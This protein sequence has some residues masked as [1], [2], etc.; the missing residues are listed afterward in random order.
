M[1]KLLTSMLLAV[2]LGA[3][4]L[5]ADIYT[6]LH[7][8]YNP[9]G[10]KTALDEIRD[11]STTPI[12]GF[13][14]SWMASEIAPV[15]PT[16][17][18]REWAKTKVKTDLNLFKSWGMKLSVG[19]TADPWGQWVMQEVIK[20]F[21]PESASFHQDNEPSPFSQRQYDLTWAN[22]F[23]GTEAYWRNSGI[24]ERG[25]KLY[26]PV[27]HG[28]MEWPYDWVRGPA[29]STSYECSEHV[30]FWRWAYRDSSYRD[31]FKPM[32]LV[33]N[34]YVSGAP[35]VDTAR[36][37][38]DKLDALLQLRKLHFSYIPWVAVTEF[39]AL[40]YPGMSDYWRFVKTGQGLKAMSARPVEFVTYYAFNGHKTECVVN[41]DG[42]IMRDR[43][44]GLI[45]GLGRK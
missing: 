11:K 34:L 21:G 22:R 42:T 29:W 36:L 14:I 9:Q 43:L 6:V 23:K 7:P 37:A 18:F 8:W 2:C 30:A 3:S 39:H 24:K 44:D 5:A 19:V 35:D 12:T 28:V 32:G 1:K 45:A 31:V 27:L 17:A 26:G 16:S 15:T 40:A 13:R 41:D 10:V 33:T 38:T 4:A 20:V 25:Y